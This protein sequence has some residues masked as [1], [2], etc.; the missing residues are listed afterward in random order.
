MD[1]ARLICGAPVPV[2]SVGIDTI[3][4]CNCFLGHAEIKKISE[5]G[6]NQNTKNVDVFSFQKAI[7]ERDSHQTWLAYMVGGSNLRV[8]P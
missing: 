6:Q 7:S 3:S 8:V 5:D 2:V 1:S 4:C